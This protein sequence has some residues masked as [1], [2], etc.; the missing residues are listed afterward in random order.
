MLNRSA[1]HFTEHTDA[2]TETLLG[3]AHTRPLHIAIGTNPYLAATTALG[4]TT[5]TDAKADTKKGVDLLAAESRVLRGRFYLQR[6]R[7]GRILTSP[8]SC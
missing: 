4:S 5:S 2:S 6:Q 3:R 7:Y 8:G 1:R